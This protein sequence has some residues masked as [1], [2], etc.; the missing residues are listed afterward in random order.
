MVVTSE[1]FRELHQVNCT[2]VIDQ[3]MTR[4]V[5]RRCDWV[6]KTRF[7]LLRNNTSVLLTIEKS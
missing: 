3:L 1:Q 4:V 7:T 5:T 2:S 6:Y